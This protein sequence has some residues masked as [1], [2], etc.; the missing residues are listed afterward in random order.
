MKIDPIDFSIY[1]FKI[2]TNFNIY[3]IKIDVKID[4]NFN[5]RVK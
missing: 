1:A 5:I 2:D 4:T 3:D